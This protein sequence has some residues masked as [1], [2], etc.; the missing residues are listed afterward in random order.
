M[1]PFTPHDAAVVC[2]LLRRG[3]VDPDLWTRS[4]REAVTRLHAYRRESQDPAVSPQIPRVSATDACPVEEHWHEQ[5]DGEAMLHA[6]LNTATAALLAREREA[7]QER[8]EPTKPPPLD[9]TALIARERRRQIEREGYTAE[10]DQG[11]ALDLV[12]AA[13]AYE[14]NAAKAPENV[15]SPPTG[16]PWA[17]RHWK[18]KGPLRNLVRAGALYQAAMDSDENHRQGRGGYDRVRALLDTLLDEVRA[19]DAEPVLK[20]CSCGHLAVA[21]DGSFRT[22]LGGV[23]HG[24]TPCYVVPVGEPDILDPRTED[25][26]YACPADGTPH[27]HLEDGG[28]IADD[29]RAWLPKAGPLRD[30]AEQAP[31]DALS[32]ITDSVARLQEQIP[33]LVSSA[34]M[35]AESALSS[36]G[37]TLDRL[38]ERLD[39]A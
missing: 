20:T 34:T 4:Q 33:S 17:G 36:L 24:L 12:A 22:E 25:P 13:A 11:R 9:A 21:A 18:P 32:G 1:T 2:D 23:S 28:W 10:H 26:R 8:A 31:Y 19:V 27:L 7:S 16:W 37:R 3:A 35:L 30:D 29:G 6:D 15:K 38:T 39:G 5:Y 14:A